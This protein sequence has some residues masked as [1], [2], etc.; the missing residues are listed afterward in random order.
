MHSRMTS[1]TLDCSQ[2]VQTGDCSPTSFY[3]G[4]IRACLQCKA[5]SSLLACR[6]GVFQCSCW[7]SG[8]SAGLYLSE[9][10]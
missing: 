5:Q 10:P 9:G 2:L 6:S 3:M 7:T 1:W 8:F 4:R